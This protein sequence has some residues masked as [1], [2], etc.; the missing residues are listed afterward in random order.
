MALRV[1]LAGGGTAGHVVP[2]LA[3]AQALQEL[4]PEV[5]FLYMGTARGMEA[6][7]VRRA[8]LPFASIA[9]GGVAGKRPDQAAMGLA[10]VGIGLGQAIGYIR[11]FRPAVTLVTGGYVSVPA[12]LAAALLRVPLVIQ[13]Q[14]AV[15]G[16][17]VRLLS[18]WA[19]V[20]AAGYP[21]VVAHLPARVAVRV[22][23]NPVMPTVMAADRTAAREALGVGSRL[24][25]LVVGGS[26]GARVINE[27]C[28]ACAPALAGND[29]L[30]V[31]WATGKEN[32]EATVQAIRT[33]LPDQAPVPFRFMTT[34]GVKMAN[35]AV[36]PYI[37]DMPAA[38][39]AADLVV[40]RAGGMTLAEASARGLPMILVP[41][42][43][44]SGH[45]QEANAAALVDAGAAVSLD[46]RQLSGKVLANLVLG[47]ARDR[48][49]L[50]A[51]SERAAALGRRDAARTVARLCLKVAKAPG[52]RQ[53]R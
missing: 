7:L 40:C 29:E 26:L 53:D 11:R 2:C 4:A 1:M 21:Q 48:P 37:Y 35:I 17:A 44:A 6:E 49:R 20:V 28:A 50:A 25:L 14:N 43:E 30:M 10:R 41:R 3:V 36:A 16:E 52:P 33:G 18:R 9:A 39:A 45:H 31:L 38:M 13:E 51:M 47:L 5:E 46:E 24:L 34:T 32:F 23:G 8:G 22:T 27:A 42:R 15:P 19:A 12:G